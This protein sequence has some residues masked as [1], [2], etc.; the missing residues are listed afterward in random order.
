MVGGRRGDRDLPIPAAAIGDYSI[1]TDAPE[2]QP[3]A[4]PPANDD[5][6][7]A[8]R[9]IICIFGS[10]SPKPGEPLYEQAYQI[11]HELAK[12]GFVVA[13]GGY[14]GIMEASS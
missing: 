12:A 8:D 6:A 4:V 7:A 5:S 13:N 10:Y 1:L 14:D 3:D 2:R 11:G 9:P